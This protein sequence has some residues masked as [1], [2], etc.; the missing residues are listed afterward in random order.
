MKLM[1]KIVALTLAAG[2]VVVGLTACDSDSKVVSKNLS[3]EAEQFR[4][5]R[6]IVFYNSI[7]DKYIATVEGRCSVD[8]ADG[9]VNTLA[10]TCKIG[11]DQY[12]KDYLGQSDNVA[13]FSLQ[14]KAVDVSVYHYE[15]I[16]KPETVV[17]D[18][19]V[20]TGTQ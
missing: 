17:P 8:P 3:T 6:K 16:F 13:W 5:D 15:V 10:V 12:I 18:L 19:R 7:T 9:L 11:D 14:E 4:I 2:F 20:E 1:T